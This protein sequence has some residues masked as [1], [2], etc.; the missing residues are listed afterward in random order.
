M[1]TG[2]TG[3]GFSRRVVDNMHNSMP[4]NW[5][6][7]LF[8]RIASQKPF[9]IDIVT[10]TNG[11]ALFNNIQ[12]SGQLWSQILW[13]AEPAY[14]SGGQILSQG[15]LSD[16]DFGAADLEGRVQGSFTFSPKGQPTIIA[17]THT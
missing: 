14:T 11:V 17:G 15:G 16:V 4:G 8:S 5:L 2:I 12:D 9:R 7:R 13:P 3:L 1:I 6:D 10:D